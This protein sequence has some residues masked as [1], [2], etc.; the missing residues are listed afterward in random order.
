MLQ[1]T[2]TFIKPDAV[3]D[4]HIGNIIGIIEK[5]GFKLIAAKIKQLSKDEAGVFYQEHKAKEFY[6]GLTEY[7]SSGPIFILC[8][9]K[10]NAVEDLRHLVGVTDP[11]EAAEGTIR[12][13]YGHTVR[14]NAIHASDGP[15]TA[16]R[17][18]HFFFPE[19]LENP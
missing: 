15:A 10:M 3:A 18:I 5:A 2:L 11:S 6:E 12:S 17:E 16:E 1:K 14:R 7:A 8:I 9:E 19:I 13:L 4:G